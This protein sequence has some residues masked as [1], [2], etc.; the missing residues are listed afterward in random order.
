MDQCVITANSLIL[1][2][3]LGALN[4]KISKRVA[5]VNLISESTT[6][7]L[8]V[9]QIMRVLVFIRL[10]PMFLFR[11]LSVTTRCFL[12]IFVVLTVLNGLISRRGKRTLSTAVRRNAFFSRI[13]LSNFPCLSTDLIIND[14]VTSCFL[15]RRAF[16]IT[17]LCLTTD[18]LA[19]VRRSVN[20]RRPLML[21]RI[22]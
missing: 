13:H 8:R 15:R 7:V 17:R 1:F 12:T 18:Q 2:T 11:C 19:N 3:I 10:Y 4:L 14:C 9:L 22:S 21:R 20:G 6:R 5:L 16:T